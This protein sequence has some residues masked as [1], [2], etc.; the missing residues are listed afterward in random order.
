MNFYFDPLKYELSIKP[1]KYTI[2][3]FINALIQQSS[4]KD[5]ISTLVQDVSSAR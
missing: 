1:K 2:W 3:R 4:V 5:Q